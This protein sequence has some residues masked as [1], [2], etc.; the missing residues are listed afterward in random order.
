MIKA[1]I[2]GDGYTAVELVRI[3]KGHPEVEITA[4]TSLEHTGKYISDIYPALI[5]YYNQPLVETDIELLKQNCNVV[6]IALPHGESM[7]MAPRLLAGGLKCI[8]LG[9]D[10]RLQEAATYQKYYEHP[11]QAPELLTE[12]VYGL[13]ELNRELIKDARL[14]ANPGCYPTGAIMALAPLLKA[15]L[16]ETDRIIVD[17]KSGVSGAGRSLKQSSLFCEVNEGVGPYGVGTHRHRP[18]IA[19]GCS[20][21]AGETVNVMFTP[22]LVPMNRGILTTAYGWLRRGSRMEVERA[23]YQMYESE[24]FVNL[25]PGGVYPNTKRVYGSNRVE[26]AW[27]LEEDS[28][29]VVMM[30][31]IDNLFR[32]ASGQAV[33]NMNLM[34]GL[35][36]K[37]GI[38]MPPVWP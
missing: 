8:D 20:L 31:A 15:G 22:H 21:A 14:I 25:L 27:W 3:L 29:Q 23:Y 37:T 1:G 35:P 32:G 28:G 17:S 4:V 38:D 34:F 12:A 36:E 6:F 19:Q 9:A 24:H 5:G 7:S 18:E 10:F 11:H 33:Q 30:S 16:L 2:V 26:I 13:P